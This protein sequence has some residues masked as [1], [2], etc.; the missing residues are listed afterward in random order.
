MK[1]KLV[2]LL[3]VFIVNYQSLPA[4]LGKGPPTVMSGFSIS[5][6]PAAPASPIGPLCL[7]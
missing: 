7:Q 3:V 1:S 4:L 5:I 2:K 6:Q